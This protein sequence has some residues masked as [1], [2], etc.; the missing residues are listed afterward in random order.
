MAVEVFYHRHPNCKLPPCNF[1][2]GIGAA[3]SSHPALLKV[4]TNFF[5]SKTPPASLPQLAQGVIVQPCHPNLRLGYLSLCLKIV[6]E[7]AAL[8]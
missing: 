6:S 1:N 4:V 7:V 2:I 3:G 8:A 5:Q